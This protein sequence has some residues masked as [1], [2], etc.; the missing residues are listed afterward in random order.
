MYDDIIDVLYPF[1]LGHTRMSSYDRCKEF[2][3]FS[4]LVGYNEA[5]VET[6]R[7]TDNRIILDEEFKEILDSKLNIIKEKIDLKPNVS[8]TYFVPDKVKTGGSYISINGGVKKIDLY[9][10]IIFI[11]DK[12]ILIDDIIDVQVEY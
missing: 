9:N 12:K 1:D 11:G 8:I 10:G 5:V 4:A 3:P 7:I 6:A 2:M